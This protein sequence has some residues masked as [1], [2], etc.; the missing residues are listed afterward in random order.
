M[1][2]YDV[3]FVNAKE[4]VYDF[5]TVN[6]S[7]AVP[8]LI[9][10]LREFGVDNTVSFPLAEDQQNISVVREEFKKFLAHNYAPVFGIS[11]W[12]NTHAFALDF[13]QDIREIYPDAL[14]VAGGPHYLSDEEIKIDLQSRRVD[15]IFKGG[16]DPFFQFARSFFISKDIAIEKR[17]KGIKVTG[18]IPDAGMHYL[19]EKGEPVGKKRGKLSYPVYP[20]VDLTEKGADIRIMVNDVCGNRCDYCVIDNKR[21]DKQY[22]PILFDWMDSIVQEITEDY[23]GPITVSL[24][25]SAPFARTNREQTKTFL[26]TLKKRFPDNTYNIF[27]DPA[28]IDN[29]LFE[30]IEKYN[31]R[32]FFMGRDRIVED[33]LIG[34]RLSGVY[35]TQEQLN[36]EYE[37]VKDF[38]EFLRQRSEKLPREVFIGYI[39]SPFEKEQDSQ[40]MIDEIIEITSASDIGRQLIVQA[41]IFLLNPYPGSKVAEKLRG[42]Y[43][44]MREFYHPIPNAWV[45]EGSNTLFLELARHIIVKLFCNLDTG[46]IYHP[47]LQLCHDI[48]FNKAFDWGLVENIENKTMKDLARYIIEHVLALGLGKEKD[49]ETY[50]DNLLELHYLGCMVPVVIKRPELFKRRDLPDAVRKA[51]VGAPLLKR[52][53]QMF[54]KAAGEGRAPC[55]NKYL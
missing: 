33:H 39:L 24:S 52:D 31:I 29:D 23:Q 2:V 13:A 37:N 44:P 30:C 36:R 54:K 10:Y 40:R 26:E 55:L 53:L 48:Q 42:K 6:D 25:D 12:T 4:T 14:I 35:R 28:D 17:E 18:N 27:M 38:L 7:A 8:T 34:R 47:L 11:F 43:I 20:L 9:Y 45:S 1:N 49:I 16:A 19:S 32:S 5:H 46:G 51:D 21:L 22:L 41:N 3:I 15:I 50:F